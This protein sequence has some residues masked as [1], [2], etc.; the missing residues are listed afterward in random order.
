MAS[1]GAGVGGIHLTSI[2]HIFITN[3]H[4]DH[5]TRI[6]NEGRV[7]IVPLVTYFG[8]PFE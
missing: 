7:P 5:D 8:R 2:R 4:S 6:S 3:Q 1:P